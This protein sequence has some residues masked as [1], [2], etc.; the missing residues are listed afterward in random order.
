VSDHR[1]LFLDFDP[2]LLFGGNASDPVSLS[3]RGFTSKNDKKVTEYVNSL[4]RYWLDHCIP[5]R[6]QRLSLAAPNIT[7]KTLR[8]Q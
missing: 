3:S 4:E 5:D 2:H 8:Q 6:I 1:G 7:R